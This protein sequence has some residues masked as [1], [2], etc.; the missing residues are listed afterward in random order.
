MTFY[1]PSGTFHTTEAG[2][3]PK[4]LFTEIDTNPVDGA[5]TNEEFIAYIA[6]QMRRQEEQQTTVKNGFTK[7]DSNNDGKLQLE[8]M[9][10]MEEA[11]KRGK[12]EFNRLAA[13][14]TSAAM[15]FECQ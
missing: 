9:L 1:N 14:L 13:S 11:N 15:Q 4:A 8:E 5:I 7:A 10:A 2:K 6:H 3:S 12:T